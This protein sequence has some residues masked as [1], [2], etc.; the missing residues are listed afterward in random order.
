MT[1]NNNLEKLVQRYERRIKAL[2]VTLERLHKQG[3]VEVSYYCGVID[4]LE[5]VVDDLK[6]E[7]IIKKT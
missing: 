6:E 4:E 1:D 3:S 7:L 2:K 5:D